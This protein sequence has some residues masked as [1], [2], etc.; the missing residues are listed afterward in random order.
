MK[1]IICYSKSDYFF[2][3]IYDKEPFESMMKNIGKVDYYKCSDCGFTISKT[4]RDLAK[5]EWMKLNFDFHHYLENNDVP[6]NQPPY[7]DQALMIKILLEN[8]IIDIESV[9]DYAGGYGTLSNILKKYFHISKFPV[10]DPF[11]QNTNNDIYV[12]KE[13][14]K[15]YKTV[16]NSALFEHITERNLFD[17]IN[18][19]VTDDGCMIIHTVICENIPNDS[20]WFYLFPPVHCAFHT[21]K[22]MNIL[23]K[24]WSYKSSIYVPSAKCWILFKK[25]NMNIQKKVNQI[26]LEFQTDYLI[27]KVGFVDYWKGF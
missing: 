25:N 23:M 2:S 14:L 13:N 24:Q 19:L 1:C 12:S 7:I 10:Y 5:E 26:N 17:E 8:G 9:L 27:Y 21:N 4:H 6:L 16:F 20:N 15:K 22:S 18:N 11:V 3:K